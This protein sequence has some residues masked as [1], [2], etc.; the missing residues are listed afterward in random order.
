MRPFDKSFLP[1]TCPVQRE[2]GNILKVTQL[3]KSF[4]GLSVFKNL[5]LEVPSGAFCALIGPSGC[6]KSTFFDVL[7][8]VLPMDSGEISWGGRSV[9]DLKHIAAYMQQKD[10]LLPWFSLEENAL[11]PAKI[12]KGQKKDGRKAV[13]DLFARFGLSGF[14]N[15]LPHQVSGGMRQR[16]ALVRTLT[17]DR[18]LVLLDEP[19][20]ALDALTRSMLQEELLNLQLEFGK[21]VLMI[22]HDVEEALLLADDVVILSSSPMRLLERIHITSPKPRR[23]SDPEIGRYKEIVLSELKRELTVAQ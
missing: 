14:E 10:L 21:T 11:L 15:Y 2:V 18:E 6:G 17:F 1:P 23:P 4:T 8:G 7:M 20:S 16:A 12:L 19:L 13:R 5:N 22:T 3:S 9:N